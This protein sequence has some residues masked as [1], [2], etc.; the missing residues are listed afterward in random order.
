[1]IVFFKPICG[2]RSTYSGMHDLQSLAR[3]PLKNKVQ[4]LSLVVSVSAGVCTTAA[5]SSGTT[6]RSA[7]RLAAVTD[8]AT[9]F[10]P[11]S[12]VSSL[13]LNAPLHMERW[14]TQAATSACM[15]RP[16]AHMLGC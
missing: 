9:T 10:L 16:A 1:M 5:V 4:L 13:K 15:L 8:A 2:T 6:D 12:K 14:R 3:L 7:V 11:A